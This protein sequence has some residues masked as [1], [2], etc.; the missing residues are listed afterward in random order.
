[1]NLF[2]PG[3]EGTDRLD[4]N[5]LK[6]SRHQHHVFGDRHNPR[7][8]PCRLPLPLNSNKTSQLGWGGGEENQNSFPSAGKGGGGGEG[9]GGAWKGEEQGEVLACRLEHLLQF[10]SLQTFTAELNQSC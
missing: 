4:I 1:M 7:G 8:S 9:G 2:V 3:P 10:E 6:Q 5:N